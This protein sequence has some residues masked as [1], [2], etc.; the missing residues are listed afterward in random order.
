MTL[1]ST[2]HNLVHSLGRNGG[3]LTALRGLSTLA[4]NRLRYSDQ[5]CTPA[6]TTIADAEG[7]AAP[8]PTLTAIPIL[9]V[10]YGNATD[11]VSC[12]TALGHARQQPRFEIFICENG[13]PQAYAELIKAVTAENGPCRDIGDDTVLATPLLKVRRLMSLKGQANGTLV[14]IGLAIDNL[15]YA[16]GV[17]AWLRPMMAVPGWPAI[18]VLNPDSEPEPDALLELAAHS[19]RWGKGMVGSRLVP[20]ADRTIVHSRGLQWCKVRA[21]ARAVD[22][23][24]PIE[25]EPDPQAVDSRIDSPSGAS[26]Y[27]TRACLD[28]IGLMNERYFLFFED[29]EWGLRAREEFGVGYAHRS[30]VVHAG[31]TTIGSSTRAER[32]SPLSLYLEYRNSIL[33]VRKNFPVWLP[34][35]V[36][37][38]LGRFLL[39]TRSYSFASFKAA[40]RGI[41][42]G[43]RGQTGRPI[44]YMRNHMNAKGGHN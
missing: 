24:S 5:D 30:V 32:Q 34:W 7:Q 1:L 16:G 37:V 26:M 42:D 20:T 9:I 36:F 27:V 17:N 21:V 2:E 8:M 33:F 44:D 38:Q 22:L 19:E 29:L 12:L 39:K 11:I 13:G 28:R 35:T 43:V 41:V 10:A 4:N 23:R 31:G 6:S 14:H 3:F 18:W 15:G 25:F 40:F